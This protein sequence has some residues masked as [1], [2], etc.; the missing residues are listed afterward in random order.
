MDSAFS[1]HSTIGAVYKA[2]KGSGEPT[3][4]IE[5]DTRQLSVYRV[6][7]PSSDELAGN[8][9][10]GKDEFDGGQVESD[11]EKAWSKAVSTPEVQW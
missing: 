5:D 6:D 8:H 3:R 4:V 2:R 11:S 1:L 7:L 9:G 10:S